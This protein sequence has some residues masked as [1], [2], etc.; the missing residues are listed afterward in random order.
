MKALN[1]VQAK[2]IIIIVHIGRIDQTSDKPIRFVSM[3]HQVT[4][5]H[6]FLSEKQNFALLLLYEV[7]LF[8]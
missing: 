5:L 4:Q 2:K 6:L 3:Q 8:L 1:Y 7:S